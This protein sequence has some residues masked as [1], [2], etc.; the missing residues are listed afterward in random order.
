MMPLP[1]GRRGQ[2]LALGITVVLIVIA[3]VGVV[4]PA[5]SWYG[6]R[7]EMLAQRRVLAGR[8][9]AIAATAPALQAQLQAAA[10]SGPPKRAV[11]EG[12]TDAIAGAALQQQVQD[13]TSQVGATLTSAES[14]PPVQ[15]GEYRRIGL[16]V[17]VTAPWTVM[18]ALL[19]AI[20]NATPQM[21]IDD[22]QLQSGV[23]LSAS[24]AAHPLEASFTVLAFHA[25]T[26]APP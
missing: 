22:L 19:V 2:I 11:L 9:A 8:M 25:G 17:S 3:W 16:H 15:A 21:L 4:G 7:A 23:L 20:Q 12:A 14:L 1:T 5:L 10:A 26:A 18:V 6:G 24:T 13:M